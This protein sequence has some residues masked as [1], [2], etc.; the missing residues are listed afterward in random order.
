MDNNI[1][2]NFKL[3]FKIFERS[4]FCTSLPDL[5]TLCNYECCSVRRTKFKLYEKEI[6]QIYR[7]VIYAF[8]SRNLK[9]NN[10]NIFK[11]QKPS[12]FMSINIEI[13]NRFKY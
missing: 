6:E 8:L 9:I 12:I 1:I 10:T 3:D 11:I 4:R 7:S 2:W 13:L 5:D